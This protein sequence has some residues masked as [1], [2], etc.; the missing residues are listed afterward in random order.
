VPAEPIAVEVVCAE[1][2]RQTVVPLVVD[3]GCT[4]GRAV[5]LSGVFARHPSLDPAACG[6]GI[7]GREVTRDHGLSDGDRVEIL[8]PLPEDPRERRRR[9]ARQGRTMGRD[10]A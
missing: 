5:E 3:A 10:S 9:L 7:F 1:A 6:L 4:A 2:N 8:R